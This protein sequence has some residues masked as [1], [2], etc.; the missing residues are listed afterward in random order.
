MVKGLKRAGPRTVPW[1]TPQ[2]GGDEREI[3]DGIETAD[4]RMRDMK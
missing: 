4:V 3:C 1:R 2:V